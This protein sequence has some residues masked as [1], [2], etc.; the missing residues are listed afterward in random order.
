MTAD[1]SGITRHEEELRVA[2]EREQGET[3]RARKATDVDRVSEVVA[4]EI[5]H[6]DVERVTVEQGDSGEIET[7]DDGSTSIPLFEER[8]VITKQLVVRE[9]VIIRKRT[10]VEEERVEA[11]LRRERIEVSGDVDDA[12]GDLPHR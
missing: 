4:R 9:R 11:E 7:L 6:A 12:G 8:L 10:L 3:I 1:G 2:T 5:E